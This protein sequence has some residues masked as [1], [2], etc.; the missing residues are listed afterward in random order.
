VAGALGAI[1]LVSLLLTAQRQV[2]PMFAE[3]LKDYQEIGDIVGHGEKNVFLTYGYGDPLKYHGILS[4]SWWPTQTDLAAERLRGQP[5]PPAEERFQG[6]V[7]SGT[8]YF[9]VTW[10]PDGSGFNEFA[11]QPE[12]QKILDNYQL[13]AQQ[14]RYLIFDLRHPKQPSAQ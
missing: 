4:G 7:N 13:V 11:Q 12:L 14:D 10:F 1:L 6:I 9:I 3:V 8:E 2:Q 5:S